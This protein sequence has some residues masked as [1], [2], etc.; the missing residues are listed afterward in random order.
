MMY[1][2]DATSDRKIMQAPIEQTKI[3]PRNFDEF[4]IPMMFLP[5][6]NHI[7]RNHDYL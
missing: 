1:M 3:R 4:E 7:P 2:D 6:A 5:H